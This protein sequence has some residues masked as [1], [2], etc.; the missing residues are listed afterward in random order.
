MPYRNKKQR[1]AY[2]IQYLRRHY[3]KN[4]TAYLERNRQ[5]RLAARSFLMDLKRGSACTQ[6][7]ETDVRCLDFHHTGSTPKRGELSTL[8]TNGAGIPRLQAELAKCV[9]LCKNCHAREHFKHLERSAG[10]ALL[11]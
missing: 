4:P 5:R 2:H 1:R 6:C 11:P 7:G 8:A 10:T 9:V 3:A